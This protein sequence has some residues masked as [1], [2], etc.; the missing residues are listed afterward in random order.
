MGLRKWRLVFAATNDP[1]VNALVQ[2][3]AAAAGVLCCR[4][5]E[6]E[7]ADFSGGATTHLGKPPAITLAISTRGASPVLSAKICRA[8]AA[9]IDPHF[10]TLASLMLQWRADAKLKIRDAS[11]RRQLLSKLAGEEMESILRQRGAAAAKKIFAKW[12]R[13]SLPLRTCRAVKHVH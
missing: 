8:A 10:A 1:A 12:L 13:E 7:G 6:A 2:V 5:D 11:A 9:A 3:D 4:A